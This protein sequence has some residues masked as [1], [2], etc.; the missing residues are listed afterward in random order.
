[1][2]LI[3]ALGKVAVNPVD[4]E[5][6]KA[7]AQSAMLANQLE[8]AHTALFNLIWKN[9]NVTPEQM[10]E[11]YGTDAAELFRVSSAIQDI[12]IAVKPNYK[13]LVPLCQVYF[14]ADGSA[15]T[16]KPVE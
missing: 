7:V 1:M 12:L 3:S 13:P 15:T 10:F 9:K 5:F 4:D 8:V 11:K 14:R 2:S 6:K 16:I